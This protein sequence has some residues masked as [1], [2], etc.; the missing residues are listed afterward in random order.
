[1][2]ALLRFYVAVKSFLANEDAQ[3]LVEYALVAALIT[4]AAVTGMK[5]LASEIN[6]AFSSISSTLASSLTS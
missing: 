3:D 6:V 1:M 2:N 5:H 4:F